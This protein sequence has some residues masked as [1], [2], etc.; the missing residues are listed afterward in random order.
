M[1]VFHWVALCVLHNHPSKYND[2]HILIGTRT[3][4][5]FS[6]IGVDQGRL[7]IHNVSLTL[8]SRPEFRQ[9]YGLRDDNQICETTLTLTMQ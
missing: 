3:K 5:L 8:I 1:C 9:R 6:I 2:I 4:L 7:H